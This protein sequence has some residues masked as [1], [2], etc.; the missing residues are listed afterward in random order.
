MSNDEARRNDEVRMS[1]DKA[2]QAVGLDF[3]KTARCG[4]RHFIG[5]FGLLSSF[6]VRASSLQR[7]RHTSQR[8]VATKP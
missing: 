2:A 3:Q 6:D 7:T 5:S 8:D 1:K 4:E